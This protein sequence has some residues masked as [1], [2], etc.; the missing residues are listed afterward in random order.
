MGAPK[1]IGPIALV[2]ATSL[3]LLLAFCVVDLVAV[4]APTAPSWLGTLIG[5]A[6]VLC[7]A[8]APYGVVVLHFHLLPANGSRWLPPLATS[9]LSMLIAIVLTCTVGL[10]FHVW[11]GGGIQPELFTTTHLQHAH[12]THWQHAFMNSSGQPSRAGSDQPPAEP[13]TTAPAVRRPIRSPRRRWERRI[14]A[15]TLF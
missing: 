1:R 13:C 5:G 8:A 4:T 15:V 11:I 2:A 3:A 10:A 6:V 7:L 14:A 12:C 9:F